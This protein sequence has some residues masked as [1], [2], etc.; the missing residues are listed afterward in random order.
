MF[1]HILSRRDLIMIVFCVSTEKAKNDFLLYRRLAE[2]Y[3]QQEYTL[4]YFQKI[5]RFSLLFNSSRGIEGGV[6]AT[7]Y[8]AILCCAMLCVSNVT[9]SGINVTSSLL[10]NCFSTDEE[11]PSDSFSFLVLAS[12]FGDAPTIVFFA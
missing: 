5:L 1:V 10:S 3:T 11:E 12:V 8:Y 4:F 7:L 9:F 6:Y 2:Y